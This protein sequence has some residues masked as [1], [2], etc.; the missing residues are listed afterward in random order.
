LQFENGGKIV[1]YLL[2]RGKATVKE[3]SEGTGLSTATIR[4]QVIRK[5]NLGSDIYIRTTHRK[6]NKGRVL[7]QRI[8]LV[9]LV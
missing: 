7:N 8:R 6:N 3:V 4:K 9:W 1:K 5:K 2:H